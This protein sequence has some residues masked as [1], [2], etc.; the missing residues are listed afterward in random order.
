MTNTK[1]NDPLPPKPP[2]LLQKLKWWV[3]YG[4]QNLKW[5][6]LAVILLL[7][8]WFFIELDIISSITEYLTK[9]YE[10]SVKNELDRP[11]D[12]EMEEGG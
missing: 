7:F 6:I 10:C 9:L 5:V 4:R 11:L 12:C 2:E 1:P 8:Y 3:L